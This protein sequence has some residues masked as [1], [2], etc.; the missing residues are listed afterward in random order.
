M[1][2]IFWCAAMLVLGSN[3]YA[4]TTVELNPDKD[5]SIYSESENSNGEG[6]LFSGQTCSDNSRR[7]LL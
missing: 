4:Q 5:N 7:A 2:K 3:S 6:K 1:K